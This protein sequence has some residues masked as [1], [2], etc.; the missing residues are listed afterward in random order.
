MT[1]WLR[2][3]E[4]QAAVKR[5]SHFGK[6]RQSGSLLNHL[7]HAGELHLQN[8]WDY[9]FPTQFPH[10]KPPKQLHSHAFRL[11]REVDDMARS[12]LNYASVYE[13][14]YIVRFLWAWTWIIAK[15]RA[16]NHFI[17]DANHTVC[18]HCVLMV[19]LLLE[20]CWRS[21]FLQAPKP[22]KSELMTFVDPLWITLPYL[23]AVLKA[24]S[25]WSWLQIR[26]NDPCVYSLFDACSTVW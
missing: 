11:D 4:R 8:W 16:P 1:A 12:L 2:S 17:W 3:C 25:Y 7:V 24:W 22:A 19:R 18:P 13:L 5:F 6:S 20:K 9:S 21:R 10:T 15:H 23:N 14:I 26:L